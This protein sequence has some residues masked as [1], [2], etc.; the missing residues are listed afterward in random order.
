MQDFLDTI[1]QSSPS[2]SLAG[3]S[4]TLGLSIILAVLR[5]VNLEIELKGQPR[6]RPVSL[7]NNADDPRLV[8]LNL[9]DVLAVGGS[10]LPD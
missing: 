7:L 4:I 3:T 2:F 6:L 9:L 8:P 10:L 1:Y 5:R